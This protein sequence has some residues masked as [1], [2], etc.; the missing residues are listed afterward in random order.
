MTDSHPS[1]AAEHIRVVKCP[2]CRKSVA[3]IE[4][5]KHRPFCSQKCQLIDFGDWASERHAIPAQDPPD[6]RDDELAE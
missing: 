4:S 1:N 2:H 5:E 3:W 6:N